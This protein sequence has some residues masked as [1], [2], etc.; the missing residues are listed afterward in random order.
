MSKESDTSDYWIC[1]ED[2]W[3]LERKFGPFYGDYFASDRSWQM[4]L[5]YAKFGFGEMKV[6]MCLQCV[7]AESL[8][9]FKCL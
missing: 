2:F 8:D 5:F 4:K 1:D 3:W 9:N 7:G 6:W